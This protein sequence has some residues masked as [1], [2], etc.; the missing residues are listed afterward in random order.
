[1]KNSS[2]TVL[3]FLILIVVVLVSGISISLY[4]LQKET[5]GRQTAE[6]SLEVF[7]GKTAK[8]EA[9]LKESQA[10]IEVLT[11]KN[12]DAD[13]KINS[14]L[15]EIEIEKG[16]RE[17]IK[18]ENQKLKDDLAAEVKNK[19]ELREKMTKDIEDAQAKLAE[20]QKKSSADKSQIEDLQKKLADID[21]KNKDLEKQLKVLNEGITARQNR[22]E[23]VPPP[24]VNT[25][26]KVELDRIVV[27]P[28]T[29]KEGHVL[30]V[31]TETEFL[32]FDL[33]S[34][35]GIKQGDIMSIYRGKVYLGDVRV[36]RVQE[37]MAAADFVPPFSSRKVHKNDQVVPKR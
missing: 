23:I 30:N 1:M 12:K 19:L 16:L 3:I 22:P 10:Q 27:T 14:L 6:A 18:K 32:I 8:L 5:Q 31:D 4:L 36:T 13:D 11:G 25:E 28:E 2:R 35:H 9:S 17:E 21:I 24:G 34:K 7:K 20:V 37:E 29:A 15:D 26:E 33:G